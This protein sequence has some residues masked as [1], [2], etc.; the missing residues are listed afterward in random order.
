[1]EKKTWDKPQLIAVVR[2]R[3]EEAVLDVCKSSG[4]TQGPNGFFSVCAPGD[5]QGC[6]TCFMG[7]SS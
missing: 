4:N 6:I 2:A 7:P 5:N 3:P 1:M